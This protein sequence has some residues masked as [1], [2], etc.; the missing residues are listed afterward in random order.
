MLGRREFLTTAGATAA[1]TAAAGAKVGEGAHANTVIGPAM[2]MVP[3]NPLEAA[4]VTASVR[5]GTCE[6]V[7]VEGRPDGAVAVRLVDGS[8]K[9]FEL[10]LL[11]FDPAAPG[12]ARAGSA[13]VYMHNHGAGVA[14]TH[15]EHGVAALALAS[16]VARREAE[17]VALPALPRLRDRSSV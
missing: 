6:V 5:F 2:T 13:A 16:H 4:G 1:A 17:G 8:G 15:E 11:A 10:E 7:G 9:P 14:S 3:P 12:V